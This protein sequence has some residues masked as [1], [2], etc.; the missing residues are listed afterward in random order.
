MIVNVGNN[1]I[2][3]IINGQFIHVGFTNSPLTLITAPTNPIVPATS[4]PV[5]Q[6]F[7]ATNGYSSTSNPVS[8][9][10]YGSGHR[11]HNYPVDGKLL[12]A[13]EIKLSDLQA[14]RQRLDREEVIHRAHVTPALKMQIV[15]RRKSLTNQ[16]A[17]LHNTIKAIKTQPTAEGATNKVLDYTPTQ[18]FGP[19]RFVPFSHHDMAS[20]SPLSQLFPPHTEASQGASSVLPTPISPVDLS[21]FGLGMTVSNTP[22]AWFEAT[23]NIYSGDPLMQLPH[24]QVFGPELSERS[25]NVEKGAQTP[26]ITASYNP[27]NPASKATGM[28]L[29]GSGAQPRRSHAVEIKK[30]GDTQDYARSVL[31]PTSPN[32]EPIEA[33]GTSN[34]EGLTRPARTFVSSQDDEEAEK[35]TRTTKMQS[36]TDPGPGRYSTEDNTFTGAETGEPGTRAEDSHRTSSTV[37][38]ADFFPQ[39]PQCHSSRHYAYSANQE[40]MAHLNHWMSD[41]D[42]TTATSLHATPIRSMNK[43]RYHDGDSIDEKSPD[44]GA[45]AWEASPSKGHTMRIISS[46]KTPQLHLT[47]SNWDTEANKRKDLVNTSTSTSFDSASHCEDVL[48]QKLKVTPTKCPSKTDAYW[49]GFRVGIKQDLV[50][51]RSDPDFQRGYKDGLLRSIDDPLGANSPR[52]SQTGRRS[53]TTGQDTAVL[54]RQTSVPSL[55]APRA[56]SN[57]AVNTPL[58]QSVEN[59]SKVNTAPISFET[60]LPTSKRK[61]LNFSSPIERGSGHQTSLSRIRSLE[62][63]S[64]LAERTVKNVPRQPNSASKAE[65]SIARILS[66]SSYEHQRY[67]RKVQTSVA[68][69]GNQARGWVQYDGS[70]EGEYQVAPRSDESN[71]TSS[72]PTHGFYKKKDRDS[73]PPSPIKRASSA[74]QKLTQLG[75]MSKRDTHLTGMDANV[76]QAAR[77]KPK[78]EDDP[79][80]MSSPEKA[81]WKAKWRKRFEDLKTAEQKEI[82]DYKRSH[83]PP[84]P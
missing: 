22:D 38:T 78:K 20:H 60:T 10:A 52:A 7:M 77:G 70:A 36:K 57:T 46:A 74:V 21:N 81:K 80:K 33:D 59:D 65:A 67:P 40:S 61:A 44:G 51:S 69:S 13:Y 66:G 47:D 24:A 3:Q 35:L 17:E 50:G 2:C 68:H 64:P 82:D 23:P 49:A 72:S 29:D 79:A 28:N 55:R 16:I 45:S 32:F 41:R 83:P 73:G 31:N 34:A 26:S 76:D 4:A 1:R 30:P 63:T 25:P 42:Q 58:R 11:S 6:P 56:P 43:F 39:N 62:P 53:T 5:S 9:S 14:A 37:N 84:R 8:L 75:G 54:L 15:E 19:S 71:L 27:T 18:P 12:T 48:T